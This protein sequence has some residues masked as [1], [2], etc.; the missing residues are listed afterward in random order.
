MLTHNLWLLHFTDHYHTK[1]SVLSQS[2]LLSLVMSFNSGRSSAS[3]LTF[4]QAGGHLT[5]TSYSSNC[6]L[7]TISRMTH[8]GSQSSL[9]S[10]GNGPHVKCLFH[11]CVFSHCWGNNVS[12][13]LFP[14]NSWCT[15]T[16]LHSCYLAIGPHATMYEFSGSYGN[17]LSDHNLL[18]CDAIYFVIV[19]SVS[20]QQLPK[21]HSHLLC[22]SLLVLMVWQCA[23]CVGL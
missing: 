18:W 11:Y 14:S 23:T 22:I 8:N 3:R 7:R 16:C 15:V 13:E 20:T 5:P 17:E 10:L 12:T 1:T 19:F 4:S 9:Y 21:S 2:S 6:C